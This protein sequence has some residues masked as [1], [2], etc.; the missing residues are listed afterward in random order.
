[1]LD[2]L[3]K[4]ALR[5]LN[6]CLIAAVALLVIDVLLGVASRYL[7]GAQ[8]K[9]TE[10]LAGVL[11]I[12]VSYLGIAAAFEARAHLGIDIL[13]NRFA[14]G[15][16]LKMAFFIHFVTLAFTLIVFEIGGVRLVMQA[17]HH[18]NVLP[19][20]QVSDVVQYLPLPVSGLFSLLFEV[21]NL[22][23]D[24]KHD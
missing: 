23:E 16:K 2:T 19:A 13:T 6:V 5:L 21:C 9:W 22:R 20:L 7:W 8:I 4:H 24:L 10:E 12:W 1:M 14:A 17:L 11:L 18:W 15:M 3:K